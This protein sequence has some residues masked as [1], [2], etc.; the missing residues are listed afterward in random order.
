MH[1]QRKSTN[2]KA[3]NTI[4]SNSSAII[5]SYDHPLRNK[6]S[7]ETFGRYLFFYYFGGFNNVIING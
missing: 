3:F 6:V 4:K 5:F 7:W 1:F 2:R